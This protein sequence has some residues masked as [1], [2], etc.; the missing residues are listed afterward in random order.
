[1][2]DWWG[3]AAPGVRQQAL[4]HEWAHQTKAKGKASNLRFEGTELYSWNTKI[5]DII[6]IADQKIY[7][8][9]QMNHGPSTTAHIWVASSAIPKN[10]SVIWFDVPAQSCDDWNPVPR[11]LRRSDLDAAQLQQV[12]DVMI[13]FLVSQAEEYCIKY[14][15]ARSPWSKNRWGSLAKTDLMQAHA[16]KAMTGTLLSI[17]D[18]EDQIDNAH[19]VSA[20]LI[21]NAKQANAAKREAAKQAAE[22]KAR[23]FL[24]GER[25][26]VPGNILL[27]KTSGGMIETSRYA[28][29]PYDEAKRAWH[30]LRALDRRITLS[31]EQCKAMGRI[32]GFQI[33]AVSRNGVAIGCHLIKWPEID[34]FAKQEGWA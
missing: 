2:S 6:I 1:M 16:I 32:G 13:S 33:H 17:P 4:V 18:T 30:V 8:M 9:S 34:R 26:T 5:G 12:G 25:V 3:S 27:R 15:R 31:Q 11:S 20:E 29:A 28:Y 21:R 24:A 19:T 7:L 23:R 10:A 14:V 22:E